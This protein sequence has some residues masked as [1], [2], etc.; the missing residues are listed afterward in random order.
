LSLAG[1]Q[2]PFSRADRQ[3]PRSRRQGVCDAPSHFVTVEAC[4]TLKC[5]MLVWTP[6]S[7]CSAIAAAVTTHRVPLPA[8]GTSSCQFPTARSAD[9]RRMKRVAA[10]RPRVKRPGLSS[11]RSLVRRR[12][13]AWM[14]HGEW[15]ASAVPGRS[16]ASVLP[17]R[18]SASVLQGRSPASVL[19]G[20]SPASVLPGG[21]P[22]SLLR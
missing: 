2:P 13:P 17:G 1:R 10:R 3:L 18:S 14:R 11:P 8:S 21:S 16:S 15:P 6:G 22:A 19:P 7:T 4:N 20:W 5:I 12:W 9:P